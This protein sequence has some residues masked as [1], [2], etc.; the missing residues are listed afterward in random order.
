MNT[1]K[2]NAS[3]FTL[4]KICV[5]VKG[6]EGQDSFHRLKILHS[7]TLSR[8][9]HVENSQ[10]FLAP[11]WDHDLS[12][13]LN[14]KITFQWICNGMLHHPSYKIR[15]VVNWSFNIFTSFYDRYTLHDFSNHHFDGNFAPLFYLSIV[16]SLLCC[17]K[18]PQTR[19]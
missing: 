4:Q 15:E 11:F 8:T 5:F 9:Q 10:N 16:M 13:G 6:K 12:L 17:Y 3:K 18:H 1:I 19:V 2:L 14:W 7:K